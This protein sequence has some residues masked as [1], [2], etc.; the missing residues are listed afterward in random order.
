VF[1]CQ[2]PYLICLTVLHYLVILQLRQIENFLTNVDDVT[3][4]LRNIVTHFLPV[5]SD[6][7]T[8]LF[9][10]RGVSN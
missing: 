10:C 4:A 2:I 3:I 6:L 5:V 1:V 9:I 8:L 7:R